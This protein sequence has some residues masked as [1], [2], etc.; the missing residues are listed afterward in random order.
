MSDEIP[1]DVFAH[2][3]AASRS[4]LTFEVHQIATQRDSNN[5]GRITDPQYHRRTVC[6]RHHYPL[7]GL[8]IRG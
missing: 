4:I 1:V 6:A 5:N 2:H 8:V 7:V 3:M